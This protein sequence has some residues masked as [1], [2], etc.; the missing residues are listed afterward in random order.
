MKF[1]VITGIITVLILTSCRGNDTEIPQK[2]D[3]T[4]HLYMKNASG[5]DLLNN[6]LP[7]AYK[8]ITL[9]DLNGKKDR[10]SIS[11]FSLKKDAD[12]INYLEYTAGASRK[13]T[14][15]ISPAQKIYQS[16]IEIGLNKS[17]ATSTLERDTLL[18]TYSWTPTL[19]QISKVSYNNSEIF[20]KTAGMPNKMTVIK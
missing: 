17:T 16:K 5:Q 12:T 15:S 20:V 13:L 9:T 6:K 14:D 10:V 18:I 7:G 3:Q 2:I 8:T 1:Y 4:M 11:S 19:F